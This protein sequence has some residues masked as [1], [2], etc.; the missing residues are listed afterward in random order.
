MSAWWPLAFTIIAETT[1]FTMLLVVFSKGR[2]LEY[3]AK[4]ILVTP[5]RY[6]MIVS[7][8]VTVARFFY[9]L[10]TKRRDWRK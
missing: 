8:I 10:W 1:L 3:A 4:G 9:D 7:D 2:R 5:L 6:G